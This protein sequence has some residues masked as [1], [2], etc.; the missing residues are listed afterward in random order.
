MRTTLPCLPRLGSA[1]AVALCVCAQP[2]DAQTGADSSSNSV[3][4]LKKLSIGELMDVEVTLVSRS[5]E[6]LSEAASAVQVL[7]SEDIRRSGA[8]NIPEALRLLPNLQ[9]AQITSSEY[10]ISA[11]GFNTIFANK[12]LVM[13][14]GR[15]VYTPLYGG[16][17]WSQQQV[18]LE[19]V[20]RI[21]VVSG[22]GGTLWGV[23]AVNGVIN[24]VT[25]NA[26]QTTG[27]LA[28][29]IKGDYLNQEVDLRYGDSLGSSGAYRVYLRHFERS[30]TQAADGSRN[31]DRWQM[32]QAGFRTDW[33]PGAQD[34][35][36]LQGDLYW[37][38][39]F[40]A[41]ARSPLDGQNLLGRW[42]HTFS[43]RSDMALQ[44]YFDRYF[45]EDA[46]FENSDR[47]RTFDLDFQHRTP[48]GKRQ[49]FL[50]GFGYRNVKDEADFRNPFVGILPP[51]K[52]LDQFN[53]FIQD[54]IQIGKSVELI[55]GTKYSH[56]VYSGWEWQ[57]SGRISWT[58]R[59]STLWAAVSRAVRSP[60]RYDVDYHL[61]QAPQPPNRP[62]VAGGPYFVSEKLVA[63][64][65]GYRFQ[66][67]PGS[68]FSA[69]L[70]YNAYHDIYSVEN[71]PGTLT[72]FI[73]NGG[74]GE[75]WGFELSGSWRVLPRWRLRGGYTYFDKNLRPK[76]GHQYNPDYLGNDVRHRA[77]LQSVLDL[78]AHFQLDVS[79]RY[80]DEIPMTIATAYVPTYT[81]FDVR[82]G[83]TWRHLELSVVGQ[84][85]GDDRHTEFGTQ[86]LLRNYYAK[87]LFRL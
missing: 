73:Q 37:G 40:T 7:S 10:I 60:S 28:G 52:R 29:A 11:R 27:L 59:H 49:D 58:R 34:Q 84:N 77:V 12:L 47:M 19:D 61:P 81:T 30:A 83:Y 36:T 8:T 4:A 66:P 9:V 72:Y 17:I 6:K 23:N 64:E 53:S 21:E 80:L 32:Q 25:K 20:E 2:A 14:D 67:V 15:T 69:A 24:I 48:I 78:P 56:N 76:E 50:W 16:V 22:P 74:V 57:P 13:I 55:L 1:L 31:P 68:A 54:A 3:A 82:L 45:R 18:L 39:R 5:P 87:L 44:V 51:Q 26:R 85:L 42:Q 71:Q 35:L 33:S 43:T 38:D 79:V 86:Q 65:L 46:A 41:K 63:H 62:S 70:F 75:S